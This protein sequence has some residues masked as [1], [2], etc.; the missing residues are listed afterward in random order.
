MELR[1]LTLGA[2]TIGGRTAEPEASAL[3]AALLRHRA[4]QID[5]SNNY[6]DGRSEAL[7]GAA[8]R[9]AGGLP[10][11]TVVFS[12]VDRDPES[13]A[14]DGDRVRRS[15]EETLSRLGL[16]RLPLLQLHDPYT[17]SLA[18]ATAPGGAV[19]ALVAL[20]EEGIAG[21]IGI[22]AG[23][24]DLL[25]GYVDT[26]AF[27]AV[28]SHNRFTL[29]DRDARP[30]FERARELGMAVLNAAPFGGGILAGTDRAAGRYAYRPA[31]P[32]LL[33]FLDRVRDLAARMSVEV[34][35]A[36]LHFSLRSPLVDSTVVGV[37]SRRR[38]EQLDALL[39]SPPPAEFFAEL[40]TLGPP[41][42]GTDGV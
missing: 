4:G 25:R 40:D 14:F 17:V 19:P 9:D 20:R 26:G 37:S 32:E 28:L 41:P 35:A 7:L 38:L 31:P 6:A 42:A 10:P 30:L 27:D 23:P 16:D 1:P 18:E 22:A 21:A 11:G 36:A 2:A 3:A 34:A 12:K 5:T 24:L 29:V 8:I 13:G 15:A 39:A 33:A